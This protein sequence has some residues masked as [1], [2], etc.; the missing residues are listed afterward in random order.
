MIIH[1]GGMLAKWKAKS[2]RAWIWFQYLGLR[3]LKSWRTPNKQHM[4]SYPALQ[5]WLMNNQEHSTKS[6]TISSCRA[7]RGSVG[8]SSSASWVRCMIVPLARRS[9][10]P[11]WL[12]YWLDI[13]VF[14]DHV[15]GFGDIMKDCH[16]TAKS[17]PRGVMEL[18]R[19]KKRIL[20]VLPSGGW[21]MPMPNASRYD[22]ALNSCTVEIWRILDGGKWCVIVVTSL[23]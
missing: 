7:S 10:G 23:I 13:V 4:H 12:F 18:R 17:L 5:N 22:D 15:V 19:G 2:A 9:S 11:E 1:I 8:I 14:T 20:F 16:R 6:W 21:R 3:H